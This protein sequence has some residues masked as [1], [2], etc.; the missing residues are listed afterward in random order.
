MEGPRFMI[1]LCLYE[2]AYEAFCSQEADKVGN[3]VMITWRVCCKQ[4][5]F[6]PLCP[7]PASFFFF[8]LFFSLRKNGNSGISS[9]KLISFWLS[10]N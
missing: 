2:F 6:L 3:I 4:F 10:N 5:L 1:C 9:V 8:F 7:P